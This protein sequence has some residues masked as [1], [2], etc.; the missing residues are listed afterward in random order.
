MSKTRLWS[1]VL[2]ALIWRS[3][4][5]PASV[6]GVE[7]GRTTNHTNW[8]P[9]DVPPAERVHKLIQLKK[10]EFEQKMHLPFNAASFN[11]DLTFLIPVSFSETFFE[12]FC[13]FGKILTVF[14]YSQ[15]L[16]LHLAK[17]WTPT[18]ENLLCSKA[19]FL[20]WTWPSQILNK[21]YIHLWSIL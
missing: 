6:T 5:T 4:F 2:E 21:I 18:L 10:F 19:K 14:G 15:W 17:F 8:G 20:C 1:Y 7:I 12:R 13:H 9:L 16:I 3:T 11:P